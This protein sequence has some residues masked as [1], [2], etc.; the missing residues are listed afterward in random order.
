MSFTSPESLEALT[1]RYDAFFIDLWGVLHDGTALYDGA[2]E[3][4]QELHRQNKKVVLLSNAPRKTEKARETLLNLGIED[5]L[6]HA[7]ITSGQAAHDMLARS[8][9]WGLHY[10]Y[11]GPSKDEDVIRGLPYEKTTIPAHAKF[12]LNAGFEHDFQETDDVLPTLNRLLAARLPLICINP[13]MEVVKQ[14]GTRMWCAGWVAQRY[15]AMGGAVTYIG[16]PYPLVYQEAFAASGIA[17]SRTLAI[18]DNLLTDILGANHAGIDSLL[19]TGGVLKSEHGTIP[20]DT[21][22]QSLCDQAGAQPTFVA[23]MLGSLKA[24]H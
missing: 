11:L 17:P 4:L 22:L 10:Y 3:T 18:G 7:L 19:I 5:H 1:L 6:Y 8:N 23:P 16:K 13:D 12:V 9:Q 24:A 15:E 14:D 20:D 2:L 21:T